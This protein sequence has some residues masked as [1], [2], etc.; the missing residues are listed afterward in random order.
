M[1]PLQVASH[2]TPFDR[3]RGPVGAHSIIIPGQST[4]VAHWPKAGESAQAVPQSASMGDPVPDS[5]QLKSSIES[6]LVTST[7]ST[8]G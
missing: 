1:K 4:Q 2:T 5:A 7:V 6:S 8:A 3:I